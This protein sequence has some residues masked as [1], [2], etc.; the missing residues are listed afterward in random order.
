MPPFLLK[1]KV[2][3]KFKAKSMR[4]FTVL[5]FSYADFAG[6]KSSYVSRIRAN[7]QQDGENSFSGSLCAEWVSPTETQHFLSRAVKN[8]SAFPTALI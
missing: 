5:N 8:S 4:N 7:M 3:Q 1:E 2:G 6:W